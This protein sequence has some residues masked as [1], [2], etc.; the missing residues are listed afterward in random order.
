MEKQC[1]IPYMGVD[2]KALCMGRALVLEK[3]HGCA[4]FSS[5]FFFFRGDHVFFSSSL[6]FR[7]GS[8]GE[9]MLNN[10]RAKVAPMV[11]AGGRV[12]NGHGRP[13]DKFDQLPRP[14][15]NPRILPPPGT[16]SIRGGL[17][18]ECGDAQ[19]LESHSLSSSSPFGFGPVGK[20][21]WPLFDSLLGK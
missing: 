1:P 8:V 18:G 4:F 5:F 12:A 14:C 7:H 16:P 20:P 10:H 13:K 15:W 11:M 6:F 21:G 2:Q 17:S 19:A 9:E 3:T